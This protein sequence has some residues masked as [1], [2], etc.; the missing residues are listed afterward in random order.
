MVIYLDAILLENFIVNTFLLSITSQTIK[1]KTKGLNLLISSAIGTLYVITLVYPG[2]KMFTSSP[3]K[4]SVAVIM[5][6]ILFKRKEIIF[7]IKCTCILVLYS[8]MF[9]G[10]CLF[11]Q[12]DKDITLYF[13]GFDDQVTYKTLIIA[14]MTAYIILSR[15]IIYVKDRKDLSNLIY[16]VDIVVNNSTKK[17]RAFLDTGNELREPVT[18]L[19]V[20][21][22]ERS[23]FQD[24]VIDEKE[25][26]NI[27]FKVVSGSI[28]KLEGFRPKCVKIYMGKS[29]ETKDLV[30]ALS[31]SKLS[32]LNEYQ[33]L[34]SRGVF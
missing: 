31:D 27:P 21:V 11:I 32:D 5:I 9:A 20:M 16:T 34:L 8:M 13:G 25:K 15:I 24:M 7:N 26:Y 3:F 17:I 29:I 2:L 28:G 4:I 33:A 23:V 30:I 6:L 10:M 12:M 18:N 14:M 1:V 19:P 22:V